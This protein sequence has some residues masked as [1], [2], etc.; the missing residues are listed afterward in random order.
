MSDIQEIRPGIELPKGLTAHD[1][2]LLEDTIIA[3]TKN[4]GQFSGNLQNSIS[5]RACQKIVFRG[6]GC[7]QSDKF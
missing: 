3:I 4:S 5:R 6:G 2:Q 7:E 1:Q